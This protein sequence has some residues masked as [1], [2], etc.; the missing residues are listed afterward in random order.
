MAVGT[1]RLVKALGGPSILKRQVR[2]ISDLDGL[3]LQGLPFQSLERLMESFHLGRGDIETL[4]LIPP[5][6]LA[7][8]KTARRMTVGESDR[9]IRL[10]RVATYAAE[11]LGTEE[12]AAEWLRRSNRALGN[13]TPLEL[14]K[15][16]IGARQVEDVLGRIQHGVYS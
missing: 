6:T 10:A 14:L 13:K 16:D 7:R 3:V 9:L 2:S 1:E 4:L 8:R 12:K 15:T 11:I 5:R